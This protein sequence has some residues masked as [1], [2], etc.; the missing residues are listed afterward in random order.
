M[1][2]KTKSLGRLRGMLLRD[3]LFDSLHRLLKKCQQMF[4]D[5]KREC[6]SH[7]GR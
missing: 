3:T 4:V 5:D 1:K 6:S 2:T 7:M